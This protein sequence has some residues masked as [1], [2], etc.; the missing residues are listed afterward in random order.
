MI[1]FVL[2]LAARPPGQL[3]VCETCKHMDFHPEGQTAVCRDC[4]P[5][6]AV[7][8]D[9]ARNR[10]EVVCRWATV[11]W[12]LV[13]KDSIAAWLAADP[14]MPPVVVRAMEDYYDKHPFA[15]V[16]VVPE[17]RA[18][19]A[20][21]QIDQNGVVAIQADRDVKKGDPMFLSGT[22]IGTAVTAAKAG[23]L[24]ELQLG[25]KPIAPLS[26]A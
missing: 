19:Q 8:Q 10:I 18:T 26:K 12:T 21:V 16:R 23:E 5:F 11:D 3:M 14:K 1:R 9:N 6:L 17:G 4:S 24:V 15:Q 20:D 22:P 25:R 7:R 13:G 2:Q